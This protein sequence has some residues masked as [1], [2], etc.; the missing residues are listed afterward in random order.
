MQ[1]LK[2]QTRLRVKAW[3]APLTGDRILGNGIDIVKSP[4]G[5]LSCPVCQGFKFEVSKYGDTARL[6]I[7]CVKCNWSERILLPADCNLSNLPNGRFTCFK[8]KE[9]GMIVIK[10]GEA[11]CLGCESCK[12]QVVISIKNKGGIILA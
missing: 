6:E 12:T 1:L 8:H 10:N 3:E 2:K 4:D 9:R 7:G 11:L 5:H